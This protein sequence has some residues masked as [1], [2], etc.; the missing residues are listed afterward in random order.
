MLGGA[1]NDYP[2]GGPQAVFLWLDQPE[3]KRAMHVPDD[4]KLFSGDNAVGFAY[5]QTEPDLLPFYREVVTN[6]ALRVLVY[7]GDT[8]PCILN[9][10]A[11]QNWTASMGFKETE[12]WRP[13]TLDGK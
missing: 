6:T 12:E 9:S 5:T 11:A 3:V 10:F 8:D 7:N 1:V 13:W 4:A 2:C